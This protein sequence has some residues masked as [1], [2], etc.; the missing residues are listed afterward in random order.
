MRIT[1]LG[2]NPVN[3]TTNYKKIQQN[4]AFGGRVCFI[5]EVESPALIEVSS[6]FYHAFLQKM[7]D[8]IDITKIVKEDGSTLIGFTFNDAHDGKIA[9]TLVQ[10]GHEIPQRIYCKFTRG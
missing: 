7:G 1:S 8:V 2:Y 9:E 6:K 10:K 4:P 5:D 3:Q